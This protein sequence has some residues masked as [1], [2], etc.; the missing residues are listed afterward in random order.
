VCS[1]R[2]CPRC[3]PRGWMSCRRSAPDDVGQ[4]SR[5]VPPYRTF[6]RATSS[7]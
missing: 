5:P 6:R 2:C 1:R 4:P 3:A 7:S